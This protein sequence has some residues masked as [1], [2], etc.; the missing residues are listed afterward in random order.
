M[1][2]LAK[3]KLLVNA[4]RF[5]QEVLTP[6]EFERVN[7]NDFEKSYRVSGETD[8]LDYR[9]KGLTLQSYLYSDRTTRTM[10]LVT[11]DGDLKCFDTG[12][13]NQVG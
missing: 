4:T 11:R 1:E 5:A 12:I 10:M 8:M 2:L 9:I 3:Q 13:V 7:F 6:E